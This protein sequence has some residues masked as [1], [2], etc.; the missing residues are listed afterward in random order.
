MNRR[1]T[2]FAGID[3][4]L[5]KPCEFIRKAS[6]ACSVKYPN[7]KESMCMREFENYKMCIK[8]AKKHQQKKSGLLG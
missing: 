5:D 2:A 1:K 8:E 4:S 6:L 3:W 7:D